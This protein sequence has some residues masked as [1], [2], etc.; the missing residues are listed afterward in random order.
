MLR[1]ASLAVTAA[2]IDVSFVGIG[3]NGHLAFNDPPADF[4]TGQ[5]YLVVSLD[6]ACRQQQVNEGWF[7][8][9]EAVP[10]RAISMSV[11]Q[12]L[13]TGEILCMVPGR[14]KARAVRAT[15]GGEITPSVPASA[16]RQHP[17]ATLY[18][19]R[20]SA[21]LLPREMIDQIID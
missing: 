8:S 14:H 11:R 5:P 13:E 10:T 9:L 20:E 15:L 4:A 12:V 1:A 16:L 7:P 6:H 2:P 21:G 19:D 18:L 3:E 17:R